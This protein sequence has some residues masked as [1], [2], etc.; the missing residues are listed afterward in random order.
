[1]PEAI[2]LRCG[3]EKDAAWARCSR[4]SFDPTTKSDDLVKSVYLSVGRFDADDEKKLY[5][6]ALTD[7]SRD[8]E[9]GKSIRYD[10]TEILRLTKQKSM[11]EKI[12]WFAPWIAVGELFL[13]P[14][15]FVFGML[16]LAKL[17]KLLN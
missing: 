1:M 6:K 2:C 9:D 17:I 16:I 3:F 11:M 12:P 14:A 13:V 8:I 5:R 10:K 15:I 4:C 7:M